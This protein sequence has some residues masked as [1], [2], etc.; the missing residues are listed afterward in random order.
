M[1][2]L[3]IA[4]HDN[5]GLKDAT[6]KAL[7]AAKQMGG[8]VHVMVAGNKADGAAKEAGVTILN[9]IGVDPGID[10]MSAMRIIH[11]AESEGARQAEING[12]GLGVWR[13]AIG[14]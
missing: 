14:G 2:I 4:E 12:T 8:D 9:E 3:L 10:H 11:Q 7:T 6:H 13:S 1:A 5:A